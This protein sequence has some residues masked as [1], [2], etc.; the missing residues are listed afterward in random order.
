MHN[1][2]STDPAL[3]PPKNTKVLFSGISRDPILAAA[4]RLRCGLRGLII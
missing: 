2:D 4:E 3:I 1:P